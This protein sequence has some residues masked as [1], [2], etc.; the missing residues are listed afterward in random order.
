MTKAKAGAVG[1][2]TGTV[3]HRREFRFVLTVEANVRKDNP[4]DVE[5]IESFVQL[6][7]MAMPSHP[8]HVRRPVGIVGVGLVGPFETVATR[9]GKEERGPWQAIPDPRDKPEPG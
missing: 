8:P 9:S 3:Y 1:T 4:G 6:A 7:A 2:S 5:A